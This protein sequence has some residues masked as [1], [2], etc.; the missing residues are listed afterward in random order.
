MIH[1]GFPI[2][3]FTVNTSP[4]FK[5]LHMQLYIESVSRLVHCSKVTWCNQSFR[6]TDSLLAIRFSDSTTF[7]ELTGPLTPIRKERFRFRKFC[8][9]EEYR[10][11]TSKRLLPLSHLSH[12]PTEPREA[13]MVVEEQPPQ[14]Q[15]PYLDDQIIEEAAEAVNVVA[16]ASVSGEQR[17]VKRAAQ[18][19]VDDRLFMW[20][21]VGI[22]IATVVHGRV[23]KH[24]EPNQMYVH[25]YFS[26]T[27]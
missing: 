26:S 11:L 24:D 7:D 20:A 27:L 1:A 8:C 19:P 2:F 3:D 18:K 9:H 5:S 6:M 25:N 10:I 21:V 16:K 23:L 4:S 13:I 15:T 22:T 12:S 14:Q 17:M